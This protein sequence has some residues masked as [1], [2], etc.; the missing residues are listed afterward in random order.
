MTLPQERLDGAERFADA[1]LHRL[2]P[3]RLRGGRDLRSGHRRADQATDPH[4]PDGGRRAADPGGQRIRSIG[5]G[6][7]L[8]EAWQLK[9]SLSGAVSNTQVD[10]IYAEARRGGA[11]GGKLL[12]AGGGGF[13]L[14][15]VP[16]GCRQQVKERLRDLLWVPFRFDTSGSQII[17]YSPQ[18]DYAELDHARSG[19][20]VPTCREAFAALRYLR[21]ALHKQISP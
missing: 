12:G 5:F 15:Y 8:D 1:L 7:L 2:A 19:S 13:L 3:H 18:Q 9:R 16:P 20:P 21:D 14:F 17:F 4:A 6:D 11:R 10:E